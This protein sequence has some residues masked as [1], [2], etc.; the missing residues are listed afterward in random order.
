MRGETDMELNMF[1][2]NKLPAPKRM[3]ELA[4]KGR[5]VVLCV[6]LFLSLVLVS[7][8]ACSVWDWDLYMSISGPVV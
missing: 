6:D 5:K 7:H 8:G 1:I 3:K 2:Y 4:V